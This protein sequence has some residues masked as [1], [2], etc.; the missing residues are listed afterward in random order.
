MERRF[1][2]MP[3]GRFGT[4]EEFAAAAAYLA[5]DD[6]GFVTASSFPLNGG[7]LGGFTVSTGTVY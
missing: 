7:I 3:V 1:V 6:A 4:L 5:S 2:H